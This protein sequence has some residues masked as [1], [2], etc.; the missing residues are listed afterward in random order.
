MTNDSPQGDD[1]ENG[2]CSRLEEATG[3]RVLTAITNEDLLHGLETLCD[4]FTSLANVSNILRIIIESCLLPCALC[5]LQGLLH[6][7]LR[8]HLS[9]HERALKVFVVSFE[10]SSSKTW[11][12]RQILGTT[13]EEA[14]LLPVEG[15]LELVFC[16]IM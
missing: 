12:L 16:G 15:E 4:I 11:W 3:E 10:K 13:N 9:E 2:K 7:A 5:L 14:G 1:A 6:R 8:L